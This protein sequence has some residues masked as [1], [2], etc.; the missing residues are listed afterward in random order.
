MYGKAKSSTEGH[1][2][3]AMNNQIVQGI[4]L[5]PLTPTHST[6]FVAYA[7]DLNPLNPLP[8]PPALSLSL[9]H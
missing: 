5:P 4:A 2:E 3:E 7:S 1:M 9:N 6:F 8:Q